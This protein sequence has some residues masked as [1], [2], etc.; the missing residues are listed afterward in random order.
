MSMVTCDRHAALLD[1][2]TLNFMQKRHP[3]TG[4][5]NRETSRDSENAFLHCGHVSCLCDCGVRGAEG[6]GHAAVM[7]GQAAEA[8]EHWQPQSLLVAMVQVWAAAS[9]S[10]DKHCC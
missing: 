6:C 4:N 3:Y 7:T 10:L 9:V 1:P 2:K 5:L 8:D